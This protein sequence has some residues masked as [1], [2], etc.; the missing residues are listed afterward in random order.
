MEFNFEEFL[1]ANNITNACDWN[2][3]TVKKL[4]IY[5]EARI[6]RFYIGIN[7]ITPGRVIKE[8]ETQL[9]ICNRFLDKV[10][11]LPVPPAITAYIT[12][13]LKTREDDLSALLFKNEKLGGLKAG[14]SWSVNDSR[15]DLRT[16][17]LDSYNLVLDHEI[18]TQ[19][20]AWLWKEYRM[21]VVVRVRC[22]V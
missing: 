6:W 11:I 7:Q 5:R 13:I 14:L 1:Q 16:L 21:R 8:T 3:A 9:A 17:E 19:L 18:C 20:S 4:E 15:L 22:D 12:A 10:E 2:G